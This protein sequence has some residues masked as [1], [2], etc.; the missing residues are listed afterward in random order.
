[1][2]EKKVST[3]PLLEK[4]N[5]FNIEDTGQDKAEATKK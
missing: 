2:Q 5:R 4:E 1:M 3:N